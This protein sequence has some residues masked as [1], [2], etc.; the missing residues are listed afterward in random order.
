M[1]P[2]GTLLYIWYSWN[3]TNEIKFALQ[4]VQSEES[5]VKDGIVTDLLKYA[6]KP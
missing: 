2:T 5:P 6:C 4:H 3:E 1:P